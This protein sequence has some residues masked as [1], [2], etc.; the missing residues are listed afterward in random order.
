MAVIRASRK[1]PERR[2]VNREIASQDIGNPMDKKSLQLGIEKSK[3]LTRGR[4]LHC[5]GA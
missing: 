3:T 2:I 5:C 1:I 4:K